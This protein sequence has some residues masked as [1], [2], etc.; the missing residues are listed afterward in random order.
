M[1]MAEGKVCTGFSDPYVAIYNESGGV[2]T[3][4]GGMRLARGVEVSIEPEVGDTDPF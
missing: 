2:I 3:Y 1:N 4:T